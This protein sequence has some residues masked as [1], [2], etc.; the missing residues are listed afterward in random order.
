[1]IGVPLDFG[2]SRRGVE[3]GPAALR[4]AQMAES[5]RLI[6]HTVV[7]V[8]DIA[9]PQRATIPA[10]VAGQGFLPFITKVCEELAAE[11]ADAVAQGE[12]PLVLGGDHSLV[13]GSLSGAARHFGAKGETVGC[14]YLDTHGDLHM[15][16][17]TL[18]GNVHGMPLAHLLGHGDQRF[19]S[20]AGP[21]PAL[22]PGQ[23]ALV[24]IRDLDA[25]EKAAIRA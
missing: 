7:D 19:A 23:L 17:T 8:G 2:A 22:S 3:M 25:P 21:R 18:T 5:L 14:I 1:M 16:S 11:T 6:G 9:V 4:I 13:A 20:I 24:G 15:P 12:V 10:A